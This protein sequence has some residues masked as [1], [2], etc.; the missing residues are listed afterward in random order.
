M[1][2]QIGLKQL[3]K[4]PTRYKQ[5]RNSCLDLIFT[6]SDIMPRS[7]VGNLNIS[8][9]QLILMTWKK[10]KTNKQKCEFT[11]RSY[12]NYNKVDF[13]EQIKLKDWGFLNDEISIDTQWDLFKKNI[14]KTI[15]IMCP[16]RTFKIKQVKQPWITPRLLELIL[17]KALKKTKKNK[18]N[19]E[20]LEAKR[21]RNACTNRLRK[22]K[23]DYIRE[24]LEVHTNDQK[25][26]RKN[27]Q[28]VIPKN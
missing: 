20:W 14:I 7:G 15:E 5:H 9:H 8:D 12:R 26:I 28:Q 6:N 22:A 25:K 21:L 27:I 16:S 13:Q 24:Q 17:D 2:K 11:G 19:D 18:K 4:E 10:I 23:A 3:I 1:T